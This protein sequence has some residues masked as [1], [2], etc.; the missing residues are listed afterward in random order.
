MICY[1]QLFGS[2]LNPKQ[3][4]STLVSIVTKRMPIGITTNC[5]NGRDLHPY[6]EDE[7]MVE[8]RITSYNVC[9]TKL[10]RIM[11]KAEGGG[12]GRGIYEVYSEE[13]FESAFRITSYNVCYTKLLRLSVSDRQPYGNEI[14]SAFGRGGL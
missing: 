5:S 7:W 6:E 4:V 12:G 11:L 14:Y 3:Q 10:L 13:E 8:H 9:Y 2:K 1:R